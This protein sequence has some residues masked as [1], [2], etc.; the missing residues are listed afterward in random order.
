MARRS[1]KS[2]SVTFS[3]SCSENISSD[4]CS[5]AFPIETGVDS[6]HGLWSAVWDVAPERWQIGET[7]SSRP[8]VLTQ[9]HFHTH[10]ARLSPAFQLNFSEEKKKLSIAFLPGFSG[11]SEA[12]RQRCAN[13]GLGLAG[14]RLAKRLAW[15]SKELIGNL[16]ESRTSEGR[17]D[18]YGRRYCR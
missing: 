3:T 8:A 10:R 1:F 4:S 13:V 18:V 6:Q 17:L 16:R 11:A 12:I 15:G 14:K 9:S 2:L 7:A 5:A